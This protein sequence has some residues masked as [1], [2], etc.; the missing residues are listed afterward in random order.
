MSYLYT[1]A[2]TWTSTISVPSNTDL[3]RASADLHTTLKRLADRNMWLT[4]HVTVEVIKVTDCSW[5]TPTTTE[6]I[7]SV[8]YTSI[9]VNTSAL[10]AMMV[11]ATPLWHAGSS[12]FGSKS[13][14][15]VIDGGL[16]G[17]TSCR[18]DRTFTQ[19]SSNLSTI[20][21]GGTSTQKASMSITVYANNDAAGGQPTDGSAWLAAV[22]FTLIKVRA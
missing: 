20:L 8:G 22:A 19:T 18:I 16:T 17:V 9:T 2:D 6:S 10:Q 5:G 21:M 15:L 11:L 3:G 4:N 13:A 14:V 7:G 12:T 1:P